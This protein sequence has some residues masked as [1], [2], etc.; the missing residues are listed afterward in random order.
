MAGE[1]EGSLT[2]TK[3]N[4]GKLKRLRLRGKIKKIF[5]SGFAPP[6]DLGEFPPKKAVQVHA[7]VALEKEGG[8][9]LQKEERDLLRN[10]NPFKSMGA[11]GLHPRVLSELAVVIVRLLTI[12]FERS[13]RLRR[14]SMTGERQMMHPS[15]ERAR[16]TMWGTTEQS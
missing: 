10:L 2:S 1:A 11:D 12:I 5:A 9:Q 7:A 6:C 16:R 15:S 3:E 4:V 8:F 14:S 13:W